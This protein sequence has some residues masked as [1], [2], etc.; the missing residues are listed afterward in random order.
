MSVIDGDGNDNNR[1]RWKNK[2]IEILYQCVTENSDEEKSQFRYL[3]I[4]IAAKW[5][6]Q[7]LNI[8]IQGQSTDISVFETLF[9]FFTTFEYHIGYNVSIC[10][11]EL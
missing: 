3:S 4:R 1:N 8:L 9:S 5:M 10:H 2:S 7:E 6:F 11:R